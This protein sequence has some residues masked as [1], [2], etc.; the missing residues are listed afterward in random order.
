MNGGRPPRPQN[1]WCP[2]VIWDLTTRCWA[3]NAQDRPSAIEIHAILQRVSGSALPI[4]PINYSH[5]TLAEFPAPSSSVSSSFS[6]IAPSTPILRYQG[7]LAEVVKPLEEYIDESIDPREYYVDL[8]EIAEGDSGSVF[9]ARISQHANLARLTKLPLLIKARDVQRRANGET[10]SVAIKVVPI[11]PSGS[12]KLDELKHELELLR[13]VTHDNILGIHA[14]YMDLV[15]DSLWVRMELMER[16]LTDVVVLCDEGLVLQES[17]IAR[18]TKDTLEAL[19]FLRKHNL[20]HRDVRSDNL[21]LNSQGVLKLSDF[22]SAVK[23]TA[24]SPIVADPVG[25]VYWQAPEVR[26]GPYNALK[27]DVWSLGATVWELAQAEPPFAAD[28]DPPGNR[29]PKL[30]KPGRFSP[31][32]HYF[33]RMCSEPASSRPEP[34]DLLKNVFVNDTCSR[35]V[36]IQLLQQCV[37]IENLVSQRQEL[38]VEHKSTLT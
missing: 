18:F 36:I 9:I 30:H 17:V 10:V 38:E 13:G 19:Q 15:E 7:W 16:S 22:S 20:A 25:I 3:Q 28:N 12:K 34:Q 8:D 21:L 1:V 27:V 37:A 26:A 14:L 11:P 5:L 29:W 4:E 31:S 33:L 23:V 2:D 32:F 6:A 24:G 35:P